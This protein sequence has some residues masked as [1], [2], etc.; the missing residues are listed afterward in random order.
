M[1]YYNEQSIQIMLKPH[2]VDSDYCGLL[3][4]ARVVVDA[5]AVM[6]CARHRPRHANPPNAISIRFYD[7]K[8][9]LNIYQACKLLV[10]NIILKT[11]WAESREKL[12]D[13]CITQKFT[14]PTDR[15]K[16]LVFKELANVREK[17]AAEERLPD[18][19]VDPKAM[20]NEALQHCTTV[21]T[22]EN[23]LREYFFNF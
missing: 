19:G 3:F 18:L 21:I 8:N 1:S 6:A 22:D 15:V 14:E 7:N 23:N 11:R 5:L 17:L 12:E 10:L 16:S 4:T 13:D 9:K 20:V 2:A